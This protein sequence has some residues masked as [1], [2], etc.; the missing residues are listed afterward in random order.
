MRAWRQMYQPQLFAEV[1][2]RVALLPIARNFVLLAQPP[3][4]PLA[5]VGVEQPIRR[6]YRTQAK[7]ILIS[8]QAQPAL[9]AP[10]K[11]GGKIQEATWK[12]TQF[13]RFP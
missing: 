13:L 2:V 8:P 4:Q 3:A 12:G 6:A 10:P 1:L 9:G 5:D 11:S 7:V